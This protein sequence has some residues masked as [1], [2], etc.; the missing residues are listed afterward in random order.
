MRTLLLILAVVGLMAAMACGAT[1]ST[2][3]QTRAPGSTSQPTRTPDS[4]TATPMP[5][6]TPTKAPT[7]TPA[8]TPTATPMADMPA[9][10]QKVVDELKNAP[11]ENP[12][13]S[14]YMYQ[15]KGQ[16]V[17]Y[18]PPMCCDIW[19][20]LY[21]DKGNVIAH[22]DGG[23]TGKGDGRAQDFLKERTGEK[24]VWKDDRKQPEGMR[25]AVAPIDK[26]DLEVWK[27]LPPQY[28]LSVESGLP[29]GC[30][31]FAG[32]RV[33]RDGNFISI[34]VLNWVPS[35]PRAICTM[36]YGTAVSKVY[37]G[38]DF[39]PSQAYEIHVNDK[40]VVLKDGKLTASFSGEELEKD[41]NK[42]K[43]LWESKKPKEYKMEFSWRCFCP[44]D[45]TETVIIEVG[46]DGK[47][48]S[49]TRQKDGQAVPASDYNRYVTV[50]GLFDLLQDAID[51]V[52]Y[53]IDVKYHAEMGYPISAFID[54][55]QNI[56]DEER[57]FQ[58]KI[59]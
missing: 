33:N 47:I 23:L 12:G 27:S 57:G 30:A 3:T 31:V 21:N 10:L 14:V 6:A 16:T 40:T 48:K 46:A 53:R 37:L 26:I 32:Y 45:Y 59:V 29:N 4:A 49:V 22:P 41:L 15:Y 52:A 13:A 28:V 5:T 36:I 35:D 56:A 43:A 39:D 24:L 50:A 38:S 25:L 17:Y 51:K 2:P 20:T 8:P 54:Y 55:A 18:V 7:A 9:W 58:A 1:G 42:N 44:R 34:E 19:S 11:V